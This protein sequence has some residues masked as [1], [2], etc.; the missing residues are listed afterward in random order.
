MEKE[1]TYKILDQLI[2][3]NTPRTQLIKTVEE[4]S[5]LQK[6][7]CKYLLYGEDRH[8]DQIVEEFV[9]VNIMLIQLEM[10]LLT[11]LGDNEKLKEQF[12]LKMNRIK[13]SLNE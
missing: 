11:I 2:V 13:E 1:E 4:L 8:I 7:I 12:N 10:I 9:D 5:E 3:K 6:A